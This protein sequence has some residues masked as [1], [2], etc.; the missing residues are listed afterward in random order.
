MSEQKAEYSAGGIAKLRPQRRNANKHTQRGIGMLEQSIRRD[1]IGD[2]I[3]VTADGETISGAARL[4][5]LAEIMPGVKIVEVET[6]GNTLIVNRRT[7]IPNADD[8]RAKRL[9]VAHNRVAQ[10]DLDWDADVLREIA[11]AETGALDALFL[12][13]ELERLGV[14]APEVPDFKEYGEDLADDINICKC[15]TCGHEHAAKKY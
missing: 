5:K 6:D 10:V 7:D 9:A 14:E 2:G 1:G 3:T 8:P 15:P 13:D 12:G 4:E 11:E